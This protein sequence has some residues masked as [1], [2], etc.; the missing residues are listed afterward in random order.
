MKQNLEM[1]KLVASSPQVL[2]SLI[3]LGLKTEW[4]TLKD[5]ICYALKNREVS[6]L[7]I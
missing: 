5:W 7:S 4:K 3:L 2:Y 1:T 6:I